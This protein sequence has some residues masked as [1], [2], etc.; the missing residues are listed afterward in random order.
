M[1]EIKNFEK[2]IEYLNDAEKLDALNKEIYYQ[3]GFC[4]MQ[5][6]RIRNIKI[7]RRI[8]TKLRLS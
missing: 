3:K 1:I 4:Y 6:V 8:M 5:L 2:A 7:F